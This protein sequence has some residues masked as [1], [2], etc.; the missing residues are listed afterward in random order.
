[1]QVE[2][3]A[4]SKFE[5]GGIL[6]PYVL[7]DKICEVKNCKEKATIMLSFDILGEQRKLYLCKEH[8]RGAMAFYCLTVPY[9][10]LAELNIEK[11]LKL[12]AQQRLEKSEVFIQIIDS[13]TKKLQGMFTFKEALRRKMFELEN[14]H[15][16][17]MGGWTFF[18]SEEEE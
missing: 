11:A 14:L 16:E 18:E 9:S 4:S 8:F 17:T 6:K 7:Q 15:F 1:M 2:K 13:D 10:E 3:K 12:E 5:K